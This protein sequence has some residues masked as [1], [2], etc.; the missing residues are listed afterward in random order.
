MVKFSLENSKGLSS[1]GGFSSK[2]S[3][4]SDGH[5]SP[6]QGSFGL[7]VPPLKSLN[8]LPSGYT[9]YTHTTDEPLA[10]KSRL[11]KTMP[12]FDVFYRFGLINIS[13]IV[14]FLQ[15]LYQSGHKYASLI[16]IFG[17]SSW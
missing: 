6:F 15:K 7:R 2:K 17:F 4:F 11:K 5:F 14:G 1:N 12:K 3:P 10:Q 9:P 16:I 13:K 8:L